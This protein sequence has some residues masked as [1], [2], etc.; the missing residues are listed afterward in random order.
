M[1]QPIIIL[2]TGGNCVDILETICD[3][4][5]SGPECQYR[6]IG[7]LDDDPA[8]SG[9]SIHDFPVLGPLVD[10]KLP[11]S[12]VHQWHWQSPKLSGEEF[13][14]R[15]NSI[16]RRKICDNRPPFCLC[17]AICQPWTRHG[18]SAKRYRRVRSFNWP[19]RSDSR[20]QHCQS[21][22]CRRRFFLHCQWSFDLRR[23]SH[24]P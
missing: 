7:F 4:N 16:A 5:D 12:K 24:R 11:R 6:C 13:D 17:L 14:H 22:Q 3:L 1:S 9:T 2:G 23:G 20:R 18:N 8:K 15:K 19:P 10:A 21:R